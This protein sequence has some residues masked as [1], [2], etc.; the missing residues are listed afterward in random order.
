MNFQ[1]LWSAAGWMRVPIIV[2]VGCLF[3]LSVWPEAI[4]AKETILQASKVRAARAPVKPVP[5][6]ASQKVKPSK[7]A[8]RTKLFPAQVT[9]DEIEPN[10][11]ESTAQVLTG[12][13]PI[14]VNGNSETV[15]GGEI[16][17]DYGEGTI[18]DIEDLFKLTILQPGLKINLAG[19][20]SDL[21]IFL[22]DS[23]ATTIIDVSNAPGVGTEEISQVSLPVG[24]YLIG[25][26]IFDPDPIGPTTTS[27]VLTL[28]FN[29]QPVEPPPNDEC[30]AATIVGPLP[31]TDEVNTR[32]AVVNVND[33]V[34]LCGDGGGGKTV[35][36]QFTPQQD[37]FV[38]ATT[39]GSLP[40]DYNTAIALF[41]GTCDNLVE[42]NCNDDII[43]GV[44][45]QSEMSFLA[46][47]GITY[48]IHIAEWNGGGPNGGVP[49]GGD[50]VFTLEETEPP[51]LFQGPE[52]GNIAGGASTSTDD[53][54]GS[55]S[56][57]KLSK[58]QIETSQRVIPFREIAIP[59][60]RKKA[61]VEPTGPIGSNFVKDLDAAI[62]D[63]KVEAAL[64]KISAPVLQTNFQ[65][66][67]DE[68]NPAGFRFIPPDPIMAAGPEHVMGAVNDRFAIFDKVGTKLVEI[69]ATEWFENVLPELDPAFE[70]P[71]G[72][73]FD[74]QI[75]YD[76]F[77]DRWVMLYIA[78]DGF[79]ARSALLLSVSD[80]AN[81]LG[82]W[83][84]W[85][86]PG[87]QNG[88]TPNTNLNDYPKLGIDDQAL[89]VM[90]NQFDLVT[91]P[92]Q[93]VQIRIIG[94]AQ[95]Y[96]N[97]CGPVTWTDFW[98]LRN[99]SDPTMLTFTTVPAVTFGTP[100]V[101][102]LV[103]VDFINNTGT[104][105]NLWSLTD[106]LG[107]PTLSAVTVPVTA[108]TSPP[109]A[110]QLGGGAPPIDVGGRRNRNVVYQDGSVWTAHSVGDE[111]GQF[112]RARYVRIDV[113]TATAIEDVAFGFDNFW[114]YYPV[115]QP[116]GN[117]NLVMAFTR[118]GVSEFA[119]A[120]FTG[121][122]TI[123]AGLIPSAL[124]KAG[125]DNYVK[126]FGNSRNRWGD[127]M[128][129]ALDPVDASKVWMFVEYAAQSAN[130][131][132][133]GDR[134][135]T[136]F[137]CTTFTPLAGAQI[138]VDPPDINF[139][140][141]VLGTST[142][143]F[144]ISITN[145]GD[146]TL[147][148]TDISEPGGNFSLSD[149]PALPLELNSFES[150][151]FNV[152][153]TPT[154][155]EASSGTI[156]ITST[157]GDDPTVDVTLEGFVFAAA[158]RGVCYGTTGR[159]DGGNFITIDLVTGAGT[160]VGPTNLVNGVPGLAINSAGE[161]FA[162]SAFPEANL[163]RID[164]ATGTAILIGPTELLL[165]DAIT[166]DENDVLFGIGFE[167]LPPTFNLYTINTE[168][169]AA[170]L[171]G[172][173]EE[174][175]AGMAFDPT[176][177]TLYASTGGG[178]IDQ[179]AIYTIDPTTGE[180]TRVGATG[181]G[182]FFGGPIPDIHFDT[183]G[184]LFG[185]KGGGS[186]DNVFISIDKTTGKGT[187]VGPIG[188][189]AVSG[190]ASHPGAPEG[191]Q[192]SVSSIN[193]LT[194]IVGSAPSKTVTVSNIGTADLT[195]TDISG[196]TAPFSL[197]DGL[198]TLPA[199]VPPSSSVSF[200]VKFTPTSSEADTAVVTI[201][202]DDP[203]DP[204]VDIS[205]I[206][207]GLVVAVAELGVCYASTGHADGG[208]FLTINLTTGAGSLI[209]PTGLD[210]VPGLA[211]N[212]A[213][214][215]FATSAFPE[216]DLYRIDAATGTAI[217]KVGSTELQLLDAIAFDENDVLY[218][219]GFESLPPTF[220]LYTINTETAE[221]TLIGP[222]GEFFAGMAFDPTDG[223][224][225]ASTGGNANVQ[226][227]IFT[228]DPATGAA[229]LV[230]T[231]GLGGPTPDICFDNDGNLFGAKGGGL[232]VNNLI[233]I[234]KSTGAG[235][236]IGPIGFASVSG[237]AFALG[238]IDAV[239]EPP[240]SLTVP[241]VFTLEQNYPNP[242]NPSTKIRYSIPENSQVT[243]KVFNL[244][245]QIIRTLVDEQQE[246]NF[247]LL[248]WD[249]KD[250]LGTLQSSG[251]YII[252]IKAGENV[253]SRKMLFIK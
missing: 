100:G 15:D 202:S 79:N 208:R 87:N 124:L 121:R 96:D 223:T 33:P 225:W 241:E 35:W 244:I 73:A 174:F 97:T 232:N 140:S 194:V 143:P 103:D 45:R 128:G 158:E 104:F 252:Q 75:V 134:W 93:Y 240:A 245:G 68:P 131:G 238:I 147:T 52:S 28:T 37:I 72:G 92:F 20:Q 85:S 113:N 9:I 206:G 91:G 22:F 59:Q 167:S 1:K 2:S 152:V 58:E 88:S 27:Y 193:F 170:T 200:G 34:L 219:V 157:D 145:Q 56:A 86:I 216:A 207:E 249:G 70:E 54:V 36:Y 109:N 123:D 133:F 42:I 57:S 43:P 211:I 182:A 83:C 31:F 201:S 236:V 246:A 184:N 48:Y 76:H 11:D 247:Y 90:S 30:P 139:G 164:A 181:L 24:T 229:T 23:P 64:S 3:L 81:P 162:T 5:G 51:S 105:M 53:F 102:Y 138:L 118:S 242:F 136:W 168:T 137:G 160:F 230:G 14:V 40:E 228:I 112:T 94:K 114:Y 95:L 61:L 44:I 171:I 47:A 251:V 166:F 116:D 108:F 226:D 146:A 16:V 197:D 243:V 142:P 176:D 165:L 205:L 189:R 186:Q 179:D 67:S 8:S 227:G 66:I 17:I 209:G 212:S 231:T 127:Y 18:D 82:A 89:Y 32:G 62:I 159:M 19:A 199:V 177:G 41:T 235:T 144:P 214:E 63:K 149:L 71:F 99:P 55:T 69:S 78:A 7:K 125:E 204:S 46:E 4:Q 119:S 115:V 84:N 111:S 26:T 191:P 29:E 12:S 190:L 148:I 49:T 169:A 187:I 120:R 185:S 106:P 38:R 222:T 250:D 107:S 237:L 50:L 154:T 203:D 195:V 172:P 135:G 180:A 233:S 183:A 173:T 129:A 217:L 150:A 60:N 13:S 239:E 74:P 253:Q 155:T 215:I 65:G 220:N 210:A 39:E 175:F 10:N 80:D 196:I 122:R 130:P 248:T 153:F 132:A 117:N 218:G 178:A 156:T 98:D 213:G 21:D 110:D 6:A 126:T 101:E 224:L 25:V 163:Y 221:A 161:I 77:A 198:P 188:F 234:N 141:V 151:T 192:I